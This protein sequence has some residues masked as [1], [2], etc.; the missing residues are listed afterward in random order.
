MRGWF[1]PWRITRMVLATILS[2]T[3]LAIFM[4]ASMAGPHQIDYLEITL[5]VDFGM[6]V[7]ATI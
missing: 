1:T 2:L 3:S 7:L 6:V 4:L 5:I